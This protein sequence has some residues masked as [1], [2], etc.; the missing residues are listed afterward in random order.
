MAD[1]QSELGHQVQVDGPVSIDQAKLLELPRLTKTVQDDGRVFKGF[2]QFTAKTQPG[3]RCRVWVRV[4]TGLNSAGMA[5]LV[6]KGGN[7]VQAGVRTKNSGNEANFLTFYFE[8][9]ETLVASNQTVFRL[10]AKNG[11]PINAYHLWVF[12]MASDGGRDLSEQLGFPAHQNLG[13]VDRG[14]IPKGSRWQKPVF[15]SQ[16]PA[17]GALILQKIGNGYLVRSQLALEDSLSL[18]TTLMN[19]SLQAEPS[20]TP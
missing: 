8:V 9:P 3:E 1:S 10:A 2:Y 16:N 17:Q 7:W 20:P 5:L 15:L 6:Q 18:L 12:D 11:T 14:L 19:H 4:N 13:S